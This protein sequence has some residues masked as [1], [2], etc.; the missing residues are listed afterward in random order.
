M[1]KFWKSYTGRDAFFSREKKKQ[2]FLF[3]F[4]YKL[5]VILVNIDYCRCQSMGNVAFCSF[6]VQ[7]FIIRHELLNLTNPNLTQCHFFSAIS[8]EN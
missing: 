5:Y 7:S 1:L 6:S 3:C 4:K 2:H 8:A